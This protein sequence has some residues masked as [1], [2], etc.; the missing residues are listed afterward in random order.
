M[1]YV[2]VPFCRSF[3]TYC[4]FYSEICPG[5]IS[6]TGEGRNDIV[7][8]YVENVC[9]EAEN[10]RDDIRKTLDVNTLYIGGGT[11]SVL[12]LSLF[13]DLAEALEPY[14]PF[15]EFTVEVNPED[16]IEKGSDYALG[17]KSIGASRISMG[18][19]SFDDNLLKWM[20]RRHNAASAT[21][22]FGIL[23]EAGFNNIS[24]DLIFGISRLSDEVWTSTIE[25]ALELHPEHISAYQLS[26]EENSLLA[27]K[28]EN[29]QY[30][31]ASESLCGSQ[32]DLLCR[33]LR[34]AGYN[35]YEVSNFA[36]PGFEAVHNSAYWD[37]V[38][39]VGLGAS[40]H[41]FIGN[42][43]SWN[44]SSIPEYG[45]SEEV[46]SSEDER[47]EKIMLGLRTSYGLDKQLLQS[48]CESTAVNRLMGAGALIETDDRIRIPEERF[49]VSDEII[50]ELI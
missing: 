34:D 12:P 44:S 6:G 32:Y 33:M 26:I 25:R 41:S 45:H 10:R 18:V 7:G 5:K 30:I 21:K 23:R 48:L 31:E 24:I 27:E 39:Y 42:I 29:E 2:H 22:A 3:C 17:L 20:N 40:A 19:Q 15:A 47:I 14:A 16:I 9:N 37:R 50:K 49:F 11:P 36:V 46:L 4:G 1:I 38:P 43:R 8:R 13:S 28:V 35:H